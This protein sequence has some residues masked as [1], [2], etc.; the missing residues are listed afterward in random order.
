MLGAE[1]FA[2]VPPAAAFAGVTAGGVGEFSR[3]DGLISASVD[4]LH[5]SEPTNSLDHSFVIGDV[6]GAGRVVRSGKCGG[7]NGR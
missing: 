4:A 6:T 5:S 1:D 7:V 3:P 2:L